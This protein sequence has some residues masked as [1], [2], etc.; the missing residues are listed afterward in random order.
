MFDVLIKL[1]FFLQITN[2]D[3]V[4]RR[5]R[6]RERERE[7]ARYAAFSIEPQLDI[8]RRP[9]CS[10]LVDWFGEMNDH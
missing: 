8:A 7:E 4:Y 3:A 9:S 5:E 6:E 2:S 10:R 1:T